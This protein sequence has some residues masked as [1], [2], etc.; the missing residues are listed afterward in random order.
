MVR[1]GIRG[2]RLDA[3]LL[4]KYVCT[5]LDWLFGTTFLSHVVEHLHI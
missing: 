2:R 4:T 1:G 5:Y 3:R